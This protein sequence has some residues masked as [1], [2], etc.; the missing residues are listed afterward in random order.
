MEV[1]ITPRS[2]LRNKDEEFSLTISNKKDLEEKVR[3]QLLD[4]D[5]LIG[6]SEM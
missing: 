4:G 3:I 2:N 6:E 5:V 1:I